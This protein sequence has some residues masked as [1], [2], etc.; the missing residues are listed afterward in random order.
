MVGVVY[1]LLITSRLP[2]S[3]SELERFYKDGIGMVNF[4]AVFGFLPLFLKNY[5]VSD[6]DLNNH[7][8]PTN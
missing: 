8:G 6:R 7:S 5:F 2:Y 1:T 4:I 3:T